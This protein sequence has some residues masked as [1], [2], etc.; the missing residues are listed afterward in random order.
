VALRKPDRVVLEA[1]LSAPG[2]VVLVD[3]YD[4]GW[5]VAVDGI[6]SQLRRANVA[7]RAVA[8]PAGRHTVEYLYRPSA[9]L[10]G[11]TVSA[12][13]LAALALVACRRDGETASPTARASPADCRETGEP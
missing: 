8:V 4:P 2:Y 9:L 1:N 10:L 3:G 7:F 5:R 13:T 11:L 6:P 12:G